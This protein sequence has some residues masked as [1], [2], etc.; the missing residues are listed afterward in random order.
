MAP[1]VLSS[2]PNLAIMTSSWW[3]R[4]WF[5]TNWAQL[6][7]ALE[8]FALAHYMNGQ[9]GSVKCSNKNCQKDSRKRVR[10][11]LC[12]DMLKWEELCWA[13]RK[14]ISVEQTFGGKNKLNKSFAI[15]SCVLATTN[16]TKNFPY[17]WWFARKVSPWL[18]NPHK[19]FNR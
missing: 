7:H 1:F 6:C 3:F 5:S 16:E 15:M 9:L 8:R 19:K 4:D 18:S 12:S 13:H 17:L 10:K 14:T 2:V 11:I